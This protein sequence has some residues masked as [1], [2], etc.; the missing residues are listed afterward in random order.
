VIPSSDTLAGP[1]CTKPRPGRLAEY[2]AT[3]RQQ[4]TDFGDGRES[5]EDLTAT[6][7][8]QGNSRVI[9]R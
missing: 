6:H 9:A 1:S 3:R 7:L 8:A 5:R 2:D 4:K